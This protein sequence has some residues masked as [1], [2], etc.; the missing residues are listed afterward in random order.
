[1]PEST[2]EY[3]LKNSPA[4]VCETKKES[5]KKIDPKTNLQEQN[6]SGEKKRT[7]TTALIFDIDKTGLS[8]GDQDNTETEGLSI[9]KGSAAGLRQAGLPF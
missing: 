8:I 3:Y 7:S 4:F 1:M 5:F 9:P 6:E 2:V